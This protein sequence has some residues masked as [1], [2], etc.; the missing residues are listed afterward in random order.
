MKLSSTPK[1]FP[2]SA[3]VKPKIQIWF[4]F[5]LSFFVLWTKQ[6]STEVYGGDDDDGMRCCHDNVQRDC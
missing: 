6:H 4:F 1:S 3:H 2:E 5:F